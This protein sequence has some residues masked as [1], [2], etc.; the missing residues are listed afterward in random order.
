MPLAE[1]RGIAADDVMTDPDWRQA[2]RD[3]QAELAVYLAA[4]R[5]A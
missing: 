3:D 5:A 4:K 2:V 1:G